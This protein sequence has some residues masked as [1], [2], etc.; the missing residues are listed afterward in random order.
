MQ[1]QS[2]L[3]SVLLA[4]AVAAKGHGNKTV[5]TAS[6]CKQIHSLNKLVELASN[7]TKLD[8]VTKGNATKAAEIQAKASAAATKLTSLESN[9]TLTRACAVI[10]AASAEKSQCKQ[11]FML[12]KFV[13]VANN[14]TKL[15]EVTKGNATKEADLKVK[16]ATA[17]TKLMALQSNTTLTADCA[18][19]KTSKESTPTTESSAAVSTTSAQKSAADILKATKAGGAMVSTIILVALR[20]FLL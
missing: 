2:I 8:Q 13:D 11:L 17:Q 18:A 5:S 4:T 19:L 20:M 1:L 9:T 6:E 3:L 15:D 16:A 14:Q 12:Q 7:S 10:D